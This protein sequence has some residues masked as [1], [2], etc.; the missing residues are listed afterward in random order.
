MVLPKASGLGQEEGI[1]CDSYGSTKEILR[2]NSRSGGVWEADARPDLHPRGGNACAVL[3][4]P[5]STEVAALLGHRTVQLWT[6]FEERLWELP[7]SALAP[8]PKRADPWF[9]WGWV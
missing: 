5:V 8:V 3:G 9:E 4:T 7:P 6:G 2:G 1:A